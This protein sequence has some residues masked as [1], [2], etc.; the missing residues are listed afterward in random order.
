MW[1]EY[2]GLTQPRA[3]L[4]D[5]P[6]LHFPVGGLVVDHHVELVLLDLLV[7][8]GGRGGPLAL[9]LLGLRGLR[10]LRPQLLG[11]SDG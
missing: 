3:K 10:N 6:Y 9:L 5:R 11:D 1:Q 4:T 2:A 7:L 8:D